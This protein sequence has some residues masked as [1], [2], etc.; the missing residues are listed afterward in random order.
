MN[1]HG[2]RVYK[3]RRVLY[4]IEPTEEEVHNFYLG[5]IPEKVL[6]Y[7]GVF[8]TYDCPGLFVITSSTGY[9]EVIGIEYRPDDDSLDYPADLESMILPASFMVFG[10]YEDE[11]S[12]C[13]ENVK[14]S[15]NDVK[16]FIRYYNNRLGAVKVKEQ[17]EYIQ[18]Y[19]LRGYKRILIQAED[20]TKEE[21]FDQLSP[22]NDR[23]EKLYDIA[24]HDS[25]TGHFNW[26]YIW[27]IVA[28]F[29]L[30]G[31][32]DY[33][34]VHFDIKDFKALNVVYGH[35]IANNVLSRV[36]E[37]M[38]EQ[39]WVYFSARCHND[40]FAMMIK[41]MPEE[42]TRQ[43]L[44]KMFDE[45]TV[46]P[47]DK[48]YNVYYRCGVVPMRI[49]LVLGERVADAGKQVQKTG[50]KLY[51]TEV[52]FFTDEMHNELDWSMKI[53]AYLNK[54]IDNDEFLIHLQPKYD[55]RSNSI[56]GAEALIRWKYHGREEL[57]PS[58]FVPVFETGGLVSKLDDVVLHKV[59][60]CFVA[61]K[62]KG[63][64]LRPISVNLSRKNLGNPKLVE[65]LTAIVDSYGVEHSLIEFELTESAAYD[66]QEYL[67]GRLLGLKNR[68]FKI[69][70]DD[71]GTGFSSLGLLAV[72]PLDTLKI[73]K[74]FVDKLTGTDEF[75]TGCAI[76][77]NVISM[78][79]ELGFTC[80]A[81]GA[82]EKGQVDLLR[83]FGCEIVQGYYFSKPVPVE[84]YEK[85]LCE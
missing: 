61:W 76:I 7:D 36:T 35:D 8:G 46:L 69:S 77:R 38:K 54:A 23:E 2:G 12:I 51:E 17:P 40:N 14:N 56:Y 33:S 63:I 67:V 19:T 82:E 21:F 45:I 80:L 5:K 81:E 39:D 44:E 62:E 85:M 27:P 73:D 71:F 3:P 41:G 70:M 32:Q 48:N 59:C 4:Y 34:F 1:I 13:V 37:K 6:A 57:Y 58:R 52:L 42:E 29:G 75:R 84:I 11:D 18:I 9:R 65:H 78:A 26:N 22:E 55:I 60:Q 64:P 49:A 31:I 25:I 68:G 30:L 66:N 79:K 50:E 72:M 28:G 15:I 47:E 74:S 20:I 43:K 16:D 53:K 10:D 83:E 24:Y